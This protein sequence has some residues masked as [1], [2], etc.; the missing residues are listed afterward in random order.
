MCMCESVLFRF[1]TC[2]VTAPSFLGG[3][4]APGLNYR[5]IGCVS[6]PHVL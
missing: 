5:V 1:Y 6:R 2:I 3:G 4:G